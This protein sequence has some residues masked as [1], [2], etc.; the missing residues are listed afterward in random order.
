MSDSTPTTTTAPGWAVL[1]PG[2]IA[3]RFLSQLPASSRGA[4]LV[5]AGSSDQG[6]AAAFAA[7]AVEHGFPDATAGDYAAVL[8]DPQVTAVYISTVH[9]GHAALVLQALEAGKAVLCEKPVA[10][11]PAEVERVLAQAAASGLPFVEAYKHRFG[12][13]ARALDAAVADHEVGSALRLTASFG[14]AA[15]S[16]S[17]RLFDPALAG[18]AILD[19][20]G[21]PVSLAVG[22]AAAAG[23]DPAD[24]TLTAAA[25]RIGDTGVDEHATATVSGNGFTAEVAC[26]IVAE[27]SR[28]ATLTGSA[29]SIDLPDVFGSRAASAASFTVRTGGL[30]RVVEPATVDPFAAEADAVSLALLDGRTEAG[31]VPWAHSRAI[32]G[33]LDQWRAGLQG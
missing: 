19:V 10:P 5:A 29:G 4:R 33:L 27:L 9:T 32:A 2:S 11:T 31:E 13:F 23:V 24:L 20:G 8:A 14:F 17:G 25:G 1:G 16:R 7:E 26:S 12:P 18:G 3:R 6:R 30:E 15:G 21:Y 28:S 22:L